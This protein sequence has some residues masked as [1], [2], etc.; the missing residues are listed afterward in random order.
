[1]KKKAILLLALLALALSACAPQSPVVTEAAVAEATVAATTAPVATE[2]VD[3]AAPDEEAAQSLVFEDDFGHTIE[4]AD[5]PQ[6]IV[7]LSPSTTEILFAIGAGEQVIGRDDQSTFPDAAL[8]VTSVGALW[9]DLPTEAI[10]ALEPDLILAAEIISPEQIQTLQDLGLR[11]Y[12][13][14]NPKDFDGLFK[15]LRDIARLTGHEDEAEAL[16]ADLDAR[17]KAVQDTVAAAET[18]PS[19]FYELDGT[20]PANPWTTGSGTFIDYII[21]QAGGVNAAAALEGDYAQISTEE[22]IAQN[23]DIILLADA[24]YGTTPESVAGRAGWEAIAAVQNNAI[25]PI[26]PSIMSVPG[27][28]LVDGLEEVAHILH[29]DLFK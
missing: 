5:Y 15:N 19:V 14:A 2:A 9:G 11:V 8:E 16:I 24:L 12:Q 29:P 28:R 20:D 22:L 26:D 10:L 13:Q 25:Y 4:L 3:T 23:P 21:T 6:A 17:V 7:S 27:P 18:T 1:M